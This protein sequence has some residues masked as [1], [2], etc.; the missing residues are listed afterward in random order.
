MLHLKRVQLQKNWYNR[1]DSFVICYVC[2]EFEN[3][4]GVRANLLGVKFP[5]SLESK[6]SSIGEF[7]IS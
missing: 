2:V 6:D 4:P 5:V 7:V 3:Q 1:D